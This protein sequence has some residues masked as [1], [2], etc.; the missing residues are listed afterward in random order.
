[1]RKILLS[2]AIVLPLAG[3]GFLMDFNVFEAYQNWC[4]DNWG[5]AWFCEVD[6]AHDNRGEFLSH[7]GNNRDSRGERESEGPSNGNGEG[8][9]GEGNGE[10]NGES[11][12]Y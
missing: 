9:G 5:E 6:Y 7:E 2:S 11:H 10:S 8:E 3:C 12:D 4:Q 1:M